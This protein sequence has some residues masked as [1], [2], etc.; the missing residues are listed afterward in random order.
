MLVDGLHGSFFMLSGGAFHRYDSNG[1][2]FIKLPDSINWNGTIILMK[3]PVN[4]PVDFDYSKYTKRT[5]SEEKSEIKEFDDMNSLSL[6]L[7]TI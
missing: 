4:V 5:F 1:A 2:S 7:A 6:F 3:I